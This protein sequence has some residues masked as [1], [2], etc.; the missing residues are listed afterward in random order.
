MPIQNSRLGL[1]SPMRPAIA[2]R[3]RQLQS[4]QQVVLGAH[5]LAMLLGK[6]RAKFCEIGMSTGCNHQLIRI[7]ATRQRH[8]YSF[9]SPDQFRATL[10]KS[11]PP[12][13]GVLAWMPVRRSVPALHGIDRDAV[14]DLNAAAFQ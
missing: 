6:H 9:A 4:D 13:K 1:V 3:M 11:S 10:S 7:G 8:C 14:A 2:A 12:P 5:G